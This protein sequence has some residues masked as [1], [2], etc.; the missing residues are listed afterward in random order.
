M[1]RAALLRLGAADGIE[2]DADLT[3]KTFERAAS[4]HRA[5]LGDHTSNSWTRA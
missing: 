4:L 2:R 1:F 5:G 3:P